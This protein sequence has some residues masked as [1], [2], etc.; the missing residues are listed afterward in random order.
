MMKIFYTK[1][2]PGDHYKKYNHY[3]EHLPLNIQEEIFKY[4]LP[5]DIMSHL[6]GKLLLKEGVRRCFGVENVLNKLTYNK[7]GKPY[8]FHSDISFSLS[9]SGSYVVL[10]VG[11]KME[12]GI[13]IEELKM[14]S[15]EDF[16]NAFGKKEWKVISN[17]QSPLEQFF[18]YWTQKECSA[19]AD[20]RGL[21]IPL[22]DILLRNNVSKIDRKKW[23]LKRIYLDPSYVIH[24]ASEKR[25]SVELI[26]VDF[27][28]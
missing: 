16:K 7:Y 12:L 6:L 17:S 5:N 24:L 26:K 18:V 27:H 22:N 28:C 15:I 9:H 10:A 19:K 4:K 25:K 21:S 13:D 20:G 3:L 1:F 11:Q 23:F 2:E 14:V 8:L